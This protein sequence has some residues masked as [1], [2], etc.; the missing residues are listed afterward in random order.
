M[1]SA[2][3]FF[4][5]KK[6]SAFMITFY[7]FLGACKALHPQSADHSC[8]LRLLQTVS[9]SVCSCLVWAGSYTMT[10]KPNQ[11]PRVLTSAL[12]VN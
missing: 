8:S 3:F 11:L 7:L 5:R 6:K 1:I 12:V 10:G 4:C 9:A 2:L